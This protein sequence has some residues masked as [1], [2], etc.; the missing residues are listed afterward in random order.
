MQDDCTWIR[1]QL[2]EARFFSDVAKALEAH[3]LTCP[4][5]GQVLRNDHTLRTRLR[6]LFTARSPRPNPIPGWSKGG[7]VAA[8]L[9]L[10]PFAG[11][12]F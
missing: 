5:C 6:E 2:R 7:A 4:D 12:F 8:A 9:L 11:W 3:L 10:T 1:T